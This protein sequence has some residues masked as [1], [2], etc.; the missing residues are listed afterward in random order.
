M[1]ILKGDI[2]TQ[3]TVAIV[4][5]ANSGLLGGGGVDGAIHRVGGP[6]IMSECQEIRARQGGCPA[7]QAVITGGGSLKARFVIHTVGPV[8]SGGHKGEDGLLRS[9]YHASLALAS[10]R[11]ISSVSFPSISTGIYRFPVD[12]AARIALQTVVDFLAGYEFAEIRFLLYNDA[13]LDAFKSAL[14]EIRQEQGRA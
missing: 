8:W 11:K 14:S 5:A 13:V 9:A 4:N 6:L 7:G 10:E 3:D 12:R 1:K 2:T